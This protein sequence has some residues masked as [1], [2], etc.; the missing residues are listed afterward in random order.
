MLF[1]W[2]E[3][4]RERPSKLT[5]TQSSSLVYDSMEPLDPSLHA[6]QP[7]KSNSDR[8]LSVYLR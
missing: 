6:T 5:K 7:F 3:S 8:S 2:E 1:P 4:G